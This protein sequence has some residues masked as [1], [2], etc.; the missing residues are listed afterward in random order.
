MRLTLQ[1]C[2]STTPSCCHL[3]GTAFMVEPASQS[4]DAQQA[5][6][7]KLEEQMASLGISTLFQQKMSCGNR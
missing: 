2:R 5:Y 3:K 4:F 6:L 7:D 1:D